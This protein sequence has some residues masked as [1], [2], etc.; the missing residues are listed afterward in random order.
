MLALVRLSPGQHC[1]PNCLPSHHSLVAV[2]TE[3]NI[4]DKQYGP[5]K[6]K[7]LLFSPFTEKKLS[8]LFE[9]YLLMVTLLMNLTFSKW[10]VSIA[11]IEL[12]IFSSVLTCYSYVII[13]I[14]A[15]LYFWVLVIHFLSSIHFRFSSF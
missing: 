2:A 13:H 3:M 7:Y 6:L 12:S 15:W 5:H 4:W 10:I 8:T 14:L 9:S 1:R 11:F